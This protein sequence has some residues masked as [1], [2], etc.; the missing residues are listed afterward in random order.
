MYVTEN[1]V[2][3]LGQPKKSFGD[4]VSSLFCSAVKNNVI[5]RRQSITFTISPEDE[6]D[7][8]ESNGN[9]NFAYSNG[10]A[11]ERTD[12]S[13]FKPRR[14]SIKLAPQQTLPRVPSPIPASPP[15]NH[16]T[17]STVN[18]TSTD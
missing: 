7:E 10:G 13:V 9:D 2:G 6:E 4:L 14:L 3:D 17:T 1:E 8:E 18:E 15:S 12:N 16:V 11:K 5:N